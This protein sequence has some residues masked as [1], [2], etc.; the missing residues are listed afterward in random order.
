MG[1]SSPEGNP[2]SITPEKGELAPKSQFVEMLEARCISANSYVWFGLDTDYE[3]V[4]EIVKKRLSSPGFSPLGSLITRALSSFN[5][6]NIEA[7]HDLV[8]AYKINPAPYWVFGSDGFDALEATT[9]YIKKNHP[10]IPLILDIK[11]D[12]P[13]SAEYYARMAFDRLNA[14]AVT[15]NPYMGKDAATPFL[16]R[17]DK[18][19][20]ILVKT[21]NP[22]ADEFQNLP[23]P[24]A[25]FPKEMRDFFVSQNFVERS[26][27]GEIVRLDEVV[28]YNAAR[29]WNENGNVGVVVGATYPREL[30]DVREIIGDLPILIP[31]VGDQEGDL[32]NSVKAGR[33]TRGQGFLAGSS[34]SFIYA[35]DKIDFAQAARREVEKLRDEINQYR[36]AA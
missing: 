36:N 32:E 33:D 3:K 34:R 31:G 20:F 23:I 1:R 16:K 19:V 11:D 4:P 24:V 22:G 25:V 28:G 14:D 12:T 17:A 8:G 2:P 27:F 5:I 35:S 29:L 26:S 15:V 21:S 30:A 6:E 9:R 13:N 10:D 7:T 18:G